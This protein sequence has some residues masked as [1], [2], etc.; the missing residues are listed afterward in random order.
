VNGLEGS[1]DFIAYEATVSTEP[2]QIAISPGYLQREWTENGRRYFH[3]KMDA[4]ILNFYAFQS[5]RY[6]VKK[7]SWAGPAGPA[8]GPF[9]T[10]SGTDW[11]GG[12][13]RPSAFRLDWPYRGA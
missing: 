7:D 1:S 11:T 3:Y 2:D 12:K 6:A 10:S 8:H 9:F 4:P 5:A 13:L